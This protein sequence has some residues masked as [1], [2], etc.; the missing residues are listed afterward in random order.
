MATLNTLRTGS[1]IDAA[2]LTP[3]GSRPAAR[4]AAHQEKAMADRLRQLNSALGG[5]AS[6]PVIA[7]ATKAPYVAAPEARPTKSGSTSWQMILA[8]VVSAAL[9]A[10]ASWLTMSPG[11]APSAEPQAAVVVSVPAS[12]IAESAPP[13]AAASKDVAVTAVAAAPADIEIGAMLES[14]RQAW[15]NRDVATYLD[16]YAATFKPADGSSRDDWINTR[17]RKLAGAAAITLDL[18]NVAIEPTEQGQYQVSFLQD[19]A[20]GSYRETARGK[21]LT[22]VR[23]DGHWKIAREQQL[24]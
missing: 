19:Y 17:T 16:A 6:E 3:P 24:P 14:W 5:A 13:V 20:S 9:G 18:R 10:G 4:F 22:V 2:F 21:I 12:V 7:L 8:C 11:E 1:L 15:R 23:E